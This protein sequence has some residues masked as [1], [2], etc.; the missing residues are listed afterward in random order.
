MPLTIHGDNATI[1]RNTSA[2]AFGLLK[3]NAN[4]NLDR[5]T[6]IAVDGRLAL[7]RSRVVNNTAGEKGG[8]IAS[9]GNVAVEDSNINANAAVGPSGVGGGYANIG[10]GTATLTGTNVNN[11][12]ATNAPGG[13]DN[14][15]G[16]VTLDRSRVNGNV[17]TNC[18]PTVVVGCR[19]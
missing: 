9:D 13:F 14:E 11:N 1:T 7:V 4:L 6:G 8:G 17:P 10:P 5:I 19:G 2:A 16:P 12:R 3:V 18:A 15:G